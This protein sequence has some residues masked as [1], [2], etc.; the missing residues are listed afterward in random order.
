MS[1]SLRELPPS[2]KSGERRFQL[3]VY[4]GRDPDK[5]VRDPDTG[6]VIKQ[7]PPIHQTKV[8]MGGIREARKA[9]ARFE[10]EAGQH[11][12]VGT[13]TTV[14]K[15]LTDYLES[16]ERLGRAQGTLETYRMHIKNHIR[17]ALGSIRLNRL[18]THDV[19]RFLTNL[20]RD[21]GLSAGTI[22]LIFNVLSGA[23][24][25]AVDWGWLPTNVA[26]KAHVA[27]PEAA[28]RGHLT[29]EQLRALYDGAL[30]DEDIDMATMIALATYTG[31][32]RGELA[33]LQW[34]D[35]VIERQILTVK[36][37]LGPGVGGQRL[38]PPKNGKARTV[39]LGAEGVI[40]LM[41]YKDDKRAQVG[42][43][44]DGWMLSY[45]GGVTPLRAKSMT[46]YFGR[47]AARL[48][49]NASLHSLRHWTATELH[50]QGID[51]PTAAAQLGHTTSVMADTY[52]H[53][54]AGRGAIAGNAIA[55]VLG[56][57]FSYE[58]E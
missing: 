50:R 51:L 43:E 6:R 28:H 27:K 44:P 3:R 36:R 1:G 17:P 7:G 41:R 11:R 8:F 32:R 48:G 10:V 47:L 15:M 23:L 4:V 54:D 14:G 21:K 5:T 19:D 58:S 16:L 45:D 46:E 37:S 9:L 30:A 40:L 57:V 2:K 53:T 33:G 39:Y 52:L 42:C 34:E 22:V 24:S 38:G 20:D 29:T 31:C 26:K 13:S 56:P 35:L 49:I 18:T 55:A 25:Q 12:T